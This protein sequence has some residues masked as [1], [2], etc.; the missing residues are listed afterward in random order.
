MGYSL[1]TLLPLS[2]LLPPG[3]VSLL[4]VSS[5]AKPEEITSQN[6]LFHCSIIIIIM[7]SSWCMH[8]AFAVVADLVQRHLVD[9]HIS[10][11]LQGLDPVDS[12][13]L[14]HPLVEMNH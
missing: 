11:C 3:G 14:P 6:Y 8:D 2:R 1:E 5:G 4:G 9:S 7:T 12:H 10:P 13:R